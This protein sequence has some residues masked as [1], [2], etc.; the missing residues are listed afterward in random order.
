MKDDIDYKEL[1]AQ[2]PQKLA[3]MIQC[4]TV[5]F[6]EAAEEDE[7][8]FARLKMGLKERFPLVHAKLRLE[9]PSYRSLLYTWQGSDQKLEPVILCAHFDVVPPGDEKAWVHGPFSGDIADGELWG[10]GAQDIKVLMACILETAEKLL[11]QGF[12]PKRTI[13]LAFGGDEEIGGARGAKA[14]GNLLA[15]RGVHASFLLDEGGPIAV[16]MLSFVDRP[17]ALVGI[18]EK[19]YADVL[20]TAKGQGG[21]ASMPPQHTATGNLSRAITAIEGHPAPARLTKTMRSFLKYLAPYCSQP[22]RFLFKSAGITAPVILKAFTAAPTTNA[23]VRTTAACTML[24]AS[25][26]ENVL[27]EQAQANFNVRMLPGDTA[28]NVLDRF[29]AK[30]KLYG[31]SLAIKHPEALVEASAE[32]STDSFGWNALAS[33]LAVSHPDAVCVPFLFSAGTDTKHYRNVVSDIYRFDAFPQDDA[34]LERVHGDNERIK[35]ED[36]LSCGQFYYELMK[37]L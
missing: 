8:E 15:Q 13:F 37:R 9:E 7:A 12:S 6:Y 27:A 36:L 35:I 26:K 10:R 29:A 16:N 22:Y 2:L 23:L 17:L 25:P 28:Q 24:Q 5:S 3:W 19:G 33:A 31:A 14:I 1:F 30:V 11:E 34:A 18:A 32:S 4:R 20:V 21:H